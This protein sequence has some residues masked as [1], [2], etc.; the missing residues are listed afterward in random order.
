VDSAEAAVDLAEVAV[1][2]VDE[3]DNHETDIKQT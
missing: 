2:A 1:A 3:G